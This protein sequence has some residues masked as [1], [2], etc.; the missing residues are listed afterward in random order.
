LG[1][2]AFFALELI[3]LGFYFRDYLTMNFA[4]IVAW[5]IIYPIF[6]PD[7]RAV[8]TIPVPVIPLLDNYTPLPAFAG[9]WAYLI[10]WLGILGAFDYANGDIRV[11]MAHGHPLLRTSLTPFVAVQALATRVGG[12]RGVSSIS[13]FGVSVAIALLVPIFIST[14]LNIPWILDAALILGLLYLLMAREEAVTGAHRYETSP[15]S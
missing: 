3:M 13:L 10:I 11:W 9:I 7:F 4:W 6:W 12:R 15:K 2:L 1:G 5:I 14:F 8:I